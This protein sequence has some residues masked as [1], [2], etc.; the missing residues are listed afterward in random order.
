MSGQKRD[1]DEERAAA[2]AAL[3]QVA[4]GVTHEVRNVMTGVLGF[5]Q[6]A[7]KR[8]PTQPESVAELLE[9]IEKESQRCVEI[10][11]HFLGFTRTRRGDKL[12]V[13]LRDVVTSVCKIM[14]HQ[15]NMNR[16]KLEVAVDDDVPRVS[17]DAAA[18]KQVVLNLMIN[19]MQAQL[20]L[21][22]GHDGLVRV[23]ARRASDGAA[24]VE[25]H[26]DG[27]GVP[28]ELA[29]KIFEPFFTTKPAGQGTGMG[30]AVSRDIVEEHGGTLTLAPPADGGATFSLKLPAAGE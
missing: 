4:A 21:Q 10:L 9:L 8:L 23:T 24:L 1:D 11:T 14:A 20:P 7:K 22:N 26:D 6:V 3:G 17:A 19:A 25:V 18:L 15:L 27:P 28:A 16:V 30:L 13:D 29:G 5:T 12:P 2:L